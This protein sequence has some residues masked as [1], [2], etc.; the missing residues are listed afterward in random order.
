MTE[1]R[2][3]EPVGFMR[4]FWAA[5]VDGLLL[6]AISTAIQLGIL[7]VFGWIDPDI[8]IGAMG[9]QIMNGALYGIFALPYYTILHA[10][11]GATIGKRLLHIRVVDSTALSL[12]SV[13]RSFWRCM[14]YL[15]SYLIFGGGFLMAAFHPRKLALHDVLTNT[16]VE[17]TE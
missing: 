17:A 9:F 5:V 14:A 7:G 11:S 4:R 1:E 16:Q 8:R 10:R 12:I 6:T 2:E 3:R 15:P 13:K